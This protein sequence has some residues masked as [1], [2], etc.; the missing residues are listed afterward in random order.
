MEYF[1]FI[2]DALA[3]VILVSIAF[4]GEENRGTVKFII[5]VILGISLFYNAN[6]ICACGRSFLGKCSPITGAFSKKPTGTELRTRKVN[7]LHEQLKKQ[8]NPLARRGV[9]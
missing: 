8:M 7:P 3:L 2:L 1:I 4:V 5:A 6:F 9:E